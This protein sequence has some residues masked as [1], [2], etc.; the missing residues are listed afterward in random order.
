MREYIFVFGREPELSFLEAASYFQSHDINFKLVEW[1]NEIAIFLLEDMDFELLIKRLGGTVKIAEVFAEYKYS[2]REN[3]LN[4]GISVYSGNE[5]KLRNFLESEFKKERVKALFRKPRDKVFMPSEIFAKGLTEF[6]VYGKY[7]ARTIAVFNPKDYKERDETRP[8][9]ILLHQV[10]LRLARIL[11]NLSFAKHNLLDPFCGVGTI[12]QEAMISGIDVYGVDIDSE[13][14]EASKENLNWL[15]GRYNLKNNFK[16]IKGDSGKLTAYF[17]RDEIHAVATEPD[18]GPYYKKMPSREKVDDAVKRLENL[19]LNFFLELRQVMKKKGK[20]AIVLP[21]L[22]Y[23]NGCRDIN[24]E[25]VIKG[26]GF[27]MFIADKKIKL[28]IISKGR[29]LDRM[30]YVF[31]AA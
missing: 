29:F 15:R 14:I 31:E 28:P 25:R 4:Y 7:C 8:R 19:Y 1:K 21:R 12:L 22:K 27:E 23:K 11:V 20:V 5:T 9:Q 24:V 30:I 26:T 6:V 3:K 17:K 2:G 18:L 13:S 16:V 10:S